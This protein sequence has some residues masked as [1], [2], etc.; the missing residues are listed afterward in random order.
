MSITGMTGKL[1]IAGRLDSYGAVV[2]SMILII[3]ILS[4]RSQL[5][6]SQY[7]LAL[8]Y[9]AFDEDRR[10]LCH[11]FQTMFDAPR[12]KEIYLDATPDPALF[13]DICW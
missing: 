9:D 6:S 12:R 5:E 4:N 1:E 13:T 2:K 3:R 11:A 10:T 7:H 8:D